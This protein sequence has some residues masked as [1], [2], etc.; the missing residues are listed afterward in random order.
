MRFSTAAV[1]GACSRHP[2]RTLAVWG[3][4]LL[5]SIAALVFAL[6]GFTTEAA[7]TN[8]PQ[9]DRADA[10]L[11]AAFPPDPQRAVT[12]L[13]VVR[14][15]S[16]TVDDQQFRTFVAGLVRTG[17]ESGAVLNAITYFDTQDP[18]LVSADRHATLI[19][20][21]I[22]D[23]EDAA[24]VIDAVKRADADPDY[25][26]LVTGNTTRDHDFNELSERDLTNGE[27]KFGL[28][29]ALIILLLVFG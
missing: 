13:V 23:D 10:R 2:G 8:N 26:V 12:D 7:A 5:G 1:A 6:T 29:A 24:E 9:S 27:L 28:P 21:N 19:P 15:T 16:L 20:V 25:A 3:V 17:R 14:S 11:V 4:V 22:G 18:T